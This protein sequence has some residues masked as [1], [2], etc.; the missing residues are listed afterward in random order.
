MVPTSIEKIIKKSVQF[1]VIPKIPNLEIAQLRFLVGHPETEPELKTK[2]WEELL[3]VIGCFCSFWN[4]N[5]K[6]NQ[7]IVGA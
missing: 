4:I 6:L 3:K 2:K 5:V 1:Q 7:M